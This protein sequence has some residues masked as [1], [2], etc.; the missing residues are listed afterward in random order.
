[1]QGV[2]AKMASHQ[3]L[4]TLVDLVQQR[5]DNKGKSENEVKVASLHLFQ[6][7]SRTQITPLDCRYSLKYA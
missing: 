5:K 4:F 2:T 6:T 7:G 3:Q 1:M